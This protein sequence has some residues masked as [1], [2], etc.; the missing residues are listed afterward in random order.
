MGLLRKYVLI[1]VCPDPLNLILWVVEGWYI[2]Y[3]VAGINTV[4]ATWF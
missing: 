4:T 3:V 2:M 1:G